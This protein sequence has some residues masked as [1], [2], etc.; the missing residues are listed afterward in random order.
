ML[1][2]G[3]MPTTALACPL[4]EN[5][6]Q[7]R[8]VAIKKRRALRTVWIW[9]RK[10]ACLIAPPHVWCSYHLSRLGGASCLRD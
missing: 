5:F 2:M 6:R 8:M 1:E 9:A 7:D 4:L 10:H 3:T